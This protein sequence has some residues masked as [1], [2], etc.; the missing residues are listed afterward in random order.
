M[1]QE[2]E[3]SN[4]PTRTKAAFAPDPAKLLGGSVIVIDQP[5]ELIEQI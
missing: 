2:L 5:L 4:V 1:G 3:L